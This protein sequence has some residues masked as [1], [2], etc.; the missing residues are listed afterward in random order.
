MIGIVISILVIAMIVYM[1]YKKYKTQTVILFGG[2]ILLTAALLLGYPI[3]T[4]KETTGFAGFDIFK[5]I[6]I[7]T[8]TRV[9]GLGLMIMAVAG[10]VQ[11]MD[12][13]GASKAFVYISVKPLKI[14][15]SPYVMLGFAY[16]VGQLLKMAITSA[17]G[18]GVLLMATMYPL[19]LE[20]GVSRK[21]AAAI[22]V[23]AS[24]IDLGPA[25]SSSNLMAKTAGLDVVD[26]F[27]HYQLI[28]A[29]PVIVI[30]AVLHCVMQQY[31]DKKDKVT[32]ECE[33]IKVSK[34]KTDT[35][36]P[37][38]F[39]ILPILPLVLVF[40]FSK[41]AGSSITMSLVSAMFFSLFIAMIFEFIRSRN[42]KEVFAGLQIFFDGMGRAFATVVSL[43]VAG[44]TFAAGLNSIGVVNTILETSKIAGFGEGAMTVLLQ[45][46]IAGTAVLTGSGE[47]AMFS[48][49]GLA[50]AMATYYGSNPVEMLVPMQFTATLARSVSPISAVMIAVA[51]IANVSPFDVAKR[52]MIPIGAGVI[53]TTVVSLIIL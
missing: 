24:C 33:E 13:I 26:Y 1:V 8:S 31:F 28:V 15:Q 22:I 44:E 37:K 5:L 35:L 38:I 32:Q 12:L 34:L 48:F 17:A 43:I 27:V 46:V 7:I 36:P 50:P 39:A 45:S 40:A 42:I 2:I 21:S 29:I 14:I 52:T 10:F 3:I 20:L 41:V 4:A 53:V 30:I 51:G 9:A 11:Y 49:V 25:A 18:L 16:V 47:A 23:C 19:L 6:E